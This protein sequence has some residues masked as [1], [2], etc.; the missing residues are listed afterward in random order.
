MAVSVY[1]VNF[2]D[3]VSEIDWQFQMYE[4]NFKGKPQRWNG[5]LSV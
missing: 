2:K 3:Q 4:V 1:E 5:S